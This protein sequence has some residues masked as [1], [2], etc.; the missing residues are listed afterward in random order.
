MFD[1]RLASLVNRISIIDKCSRV[2]EQTAVSNLL[3]KKDDVCNCAV[4][5]GRLALEQ[6][7]ALL[8][9]IDSVFILYVTV[10]RMYNNVPIKK[11]YKH[12]RYVADSAHKIEFL[13]KNST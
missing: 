13:Q 8:T 3:R 7:N 9:R 4:L 12:S 6:T 11:I 1:V 2:K 10:L 5:W